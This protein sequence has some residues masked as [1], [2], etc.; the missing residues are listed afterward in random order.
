MV[1]KKLGLNFF[2]I[3]LKILILN[4]GILV[5]KHLKIVKKISLCLAY[6][7]NGFVE[8]TFEPNILFLKMAAAVLIF[9]FL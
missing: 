1:P 8:Y 7:Q 3:Y 2:R 9:F 6:C 4:P 5:S